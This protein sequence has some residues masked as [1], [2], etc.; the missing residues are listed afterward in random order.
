MTVLAI[1]PMY[2]SGGKHPHDATGAFRPEGEAF[3][4]LHGGK[5]ALFDNR[6]TDEIRRVAVDGIVSRAGP[7]ET[8]ALFCH[9]FRDGLQTGHRIRHARA[10][11]ANLAA[12]YPNVIALYA[13][14]AA[15]DADKETADD[16]EPGP[17]GAGGFAS[18]LAEALEGSSVRWVDAHATTG[19]TT[20]NPFV[21]RFTIGDLRP[22]GD[23]IV[24]P[25]SARW[26]E[27]R[28]R[29]RAD[30]E[31]RLSFPLWGLDEIHER[32]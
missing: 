32:L 17:G 10:L 30:R 13:C 16:R 22:D 31:F 14:D 6:A 24:E 25:G 29:L 19:P 23:W 26:G 11:G 5:L 12:L 3:R 8:V 21:R 27:W 28:R 15:R 18:A 9:G 20:I 1:A 7:V 4:R 2:D